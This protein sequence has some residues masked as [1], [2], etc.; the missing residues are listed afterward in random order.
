VASTNA[1]IYGNTFEYVGY[2]AVLGQGSSGNAGLKVE[3]S[4][5][6]NIGGSAI[7]FN[8]I[9]DGVMYYNTSFYKV[10]YICF[11]GSGGGDLAADYNSNFIGIDN[12]FV[13][14]G[15]TV[16][17]AEANYG[18]NLG[19]VIYGTNHQIDNNT[20]QNN[21]AQ[22]IR[23]AN[24]S[25]ISL[26]GNTV[27]NNGTQYRSGTPFEE[28][29]LQETVPGAPNCY[30]GGADTATF[31]N[32]TIDSTNGGPAVWAMQQGCNGPNQSTVTGLPSSVNGNNGNI[33]TGSILWN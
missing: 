31:Q 5:F 2:T 26:Y 27:Q 25:G 32:N 22:G 21:S 12:N 7:V 10:G 23:L 8:A 20:F 17:S 19:L 30:P 3:V 6:S 33:V 18:A 16:C 11:T 14:G 4:T 9:N 24:F 28:I 29:G 1:Y 15:G 13:D